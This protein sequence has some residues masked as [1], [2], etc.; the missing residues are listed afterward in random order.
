MSLQFNEI[1][2]A[3][4]TTQNSLLAKGAFVDMQTD[5]SDHVAV[6]EMWKDR[7]KKYEGGTEWEFD[8]QVDHNHSTKVVGL[9]E[10]DSSAVKDTMRK[11]TVPIKHVN[12]NYVYDQ[13]EPAFNR[14]P[15]QIVDLVKT[16][17]TA[18]MVSFYDA[19]EGYLWGKPEDSSDNKALYGIAYWITKSATEGFN[20][21]NPT[22]FS[23]GKGGLSALTNPRW[24]NWTAKY[25]AITKEDL[26]RKMRNANMK[27]KFRSPVSHATPTMGSM[28][29]GI[30][31]NYNVIGL[32][33]EALEAQNMNLGNDIASKDGRLLFKGSPVMYAPYLD[34][35]A[36]DP[37]YMLDWQTLGIGVLNGWENNLSAPTPVA[38]MH[39]V[40]R[41]DLDASMNMV[42]TNLRKQA[43]I[44]K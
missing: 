25:A 19:L 24:Q 39:L 34:D 20:G 8:L 38:G 32:L 12:A 42:C 37:V 13:R 2:D 23:A 30:Y 36:T 44:S 4:L 10:T 9:Y 40:R 1:D 14:G 18:M 3:V 35:D 17:Y 29:N 28:K 6:R 22:G 43:V 11:V 26:V 31:T 21:G 15:A 33:E 5:I 41:V 27:T 7:T 16:K